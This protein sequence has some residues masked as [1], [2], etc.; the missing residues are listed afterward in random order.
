MRLPARS[1]ASSRDGDLIE[2]PPLS[3]KGLLGIVLGFASCWR[4]SARCSGSCRSLVPCCARWRCARSTSAQYRSGGATVAR[5]GLA[6]AVL[7]GT[8]GL[9]RQASHRWWLRREARQ[10]GALWFQLLTNDQPQK[11]YQ[12][13]LRPAVRRPLDENLWEYYERLA[14]ARSGLEKFVRNPLVRALLALDGKVRIRYWGTEQCQRLAGPLFSPTIE[15]ISQLYA[16][17]YDNRGARTTFFARLSVARIV[18]PDTAKVDWQVAGYKGGV[19]PG[20]A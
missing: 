20:G 6:L 5:I 2:Y 9:S 15:R 18:D 7:F 19:R 14:E 1:L 16:L 12:L 17:T 3:G 11:A 13:L 10:F 4:S 8:A